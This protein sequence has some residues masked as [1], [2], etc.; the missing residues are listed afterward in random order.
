MEGGSW[1]NPLNLDL[2]CVLTISGKRHNQ[3]GLKNDVFTWA[4]CGL[5]VFVDVFPR[6]LVFN[7]ISIPVDPP[8]SRQADEMIDIMEKINRPAVVSRARLV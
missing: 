5:L 4:T 6:P 2:G 3:I 7:D 8:P 1:W